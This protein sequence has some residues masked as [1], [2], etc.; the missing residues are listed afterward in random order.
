M[1]GAVLLVL[2]ALLSQPVSLPEVPASLRLLGAGT[3][4]VPG[5]L[6]HGAGHFALG[7][8][9]TAYRL[10][11][12]E[13]LGLALT[14]AGALALF[15]S[16]A[17]DEPVAPAT[18]AVIS[19]VWLFSTSLLADLY[20]TLVPLRHR[21]GKRASASSLSVGFGVRGVHDPVFSYRALT[22]VNAQLSLQ[23]IRLRSSMWTA[24]DD[25]NNRVRLEAYLRLFQN[26]PIEL[27][28]AATYH[29][30]GTES[31]TFVTG[32]GSL[33]GRF[34]LVD[35]DEN[36][37]GMFTEVSFGWALQRVSHPRFA[38]LTQLL[39]G[40]F[41]FGIYLFSGSEISVFYDHRHDGYAAGLKLNGVPSGIAGH[42]GA[43]AIFYFGN[44][45]FSLETQIGS[46][47]VGGFGLS[48]R[49]TL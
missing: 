20:G 24:L 44:I 35:L 14:T 37:A 9:E 43:N 11:A 12:A 13:G 22:G 7:R 33:G 47:F 27:S 42:F 17:A 28:F 34:D 15:L 4:L 23:R 40:R 38:D 19:G 1:N 21:I 41:A 48:F 49:E 8:K 26:L 46:A 10:A 36:L 5:L 39:L 31:L 3:A 16:G 18:I 29:H 25:A 30:Y 6:I 2:P 45:G 32:E